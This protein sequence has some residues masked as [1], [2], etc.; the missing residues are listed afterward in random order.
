MQEYTIDSDW[1]FR[2]TVLTPM[3]IETQA[4]QSALQTRTQEGSLPVQRV[5]AKQIRATQQQYDFTPTQ[6]AGNCHP[7]HLPALLRAV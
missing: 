5:M 7:P 1:R 6:T 2:S 4:T 3:F